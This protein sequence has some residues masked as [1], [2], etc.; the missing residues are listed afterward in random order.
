MWKSILYGEIVR[1]DGTVVDL[2]WGAYLIC[3]LISLI[4]GAV[5]AAVYRFALKETGRSLLSAFVLVPPLVT[6]I[7]PLCNENLGIGL[8]IAGV[9]S[10]VRFRSFPGTAREIATVFLSVVCGLLCG[11]GYV[12]QAGLITLMGCAVVVAFGRFLRDD[13]SE[14][15]RELRVVVPESLNYTQLL[16]DLF[17]TYTEDHKLVR[18][19]TTNMGAMYELRFRIRLK[20]AEEEKAFLDAIRERN[21]NMPVL[22]SALLQDENDGL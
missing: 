16:E 18:V 8:M 15:D 5:I 12:T 7:V 2:P 22:S 1:V 14:R 13:G 19:K 3:L 11:A 20:D 9:F 17:D 21:G 6:A 4:I 10:L